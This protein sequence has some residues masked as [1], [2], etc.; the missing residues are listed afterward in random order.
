MTSNTVHCIDLS[1]DILN[2]IHPDNTAESGDNKNMKI[3]EGKENY[4]GVPEAILNGIHPHVQSS[5]LS[6]EA[7]IT[8]NS[9]VWH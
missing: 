6:D 8:R 1:E 9:V 3:N 2:G 5:K 4:Y 7:F